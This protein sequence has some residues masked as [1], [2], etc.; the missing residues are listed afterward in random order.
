[1]LNVSRFAQDLTHLWDAT[2]F[3]PGRHQK[4]VGSGDDLLLH[5]GTEAPV[6]TNSPLDGHN[7]TRK[8]TSGVITIF[9]NVA[10]SNWTRPTAAFDLGNATKTAQ[11]AMQGHFVCRPKFSSPLPIITSCTSDRGRMTWS[12]SEPHETTWNDEKRRLRTTL[13]DADVVKTVLVV[14]RTAWSAE[15]TTSSCHLVMTIG[16]SMIQW[17]QDPIKSMPGTVELL[18]WKCGELVTRHTCRTCLSGL[19][20]AQQSSRCMHCR[21]PANT[22]TQNIP[23]LCFSPPWDPTS[24]ASDVCIPTSQTCQRKH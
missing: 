6:A 10:P 18:I 24:V 13:L 3:V 22:K 5:M 12:D 11:L 15:R 8:H 20:G 1:M 21:P 7:G 2:G 17:I 14:L 23:R 19:W 16:S 9:F 4:E